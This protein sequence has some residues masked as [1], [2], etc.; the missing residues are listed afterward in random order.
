MCLEIRLLERFAGPSSRPRRLHMDP[1][2]R[3]FFRFSLSPSLSPTIDDFLLLCTMQM[4]DARHFELF[5]QEE[6]KNGAW[7]Y[8]EIGSR[9]NE[10]RFKGAAGGIF[11]VKYLKS[12]CT[13]GNAQTTGYQM[14]ACVMV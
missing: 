5:L 3:C 7:D 14:I 10:K 1:A 4:L 2:I 6:Y 11:D 12:P 9:R 8:E 13:R